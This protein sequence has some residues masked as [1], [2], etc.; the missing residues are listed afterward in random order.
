MWQDETSDDIQPCVEVLL[1]DVVFVVLAVGD[2]GCIILVG[3]TCESSR[4]EVVFFRV[5]LKDITE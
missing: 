2:N 3:I 4:P 1:S 5:S